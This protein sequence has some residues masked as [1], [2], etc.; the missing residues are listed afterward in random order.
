MPKNKSEEDDQNRN[1]PKW[2]IKFI[3]HPESLLRFSWEIFIATFLLFLGFLIPY[4]SAFDNNNINVN[5]VINIQS[6][7]IF[8]IDIILTM[9]TAYYDKG[10]IIKDRLKIFRNYLSFWFWIDA[11]TTFPFDWLK[12]DSDNGNGAKLFSFFK[13]VRVAKLLKLIRLAKLKI[14]I[15]RIEDQIAN[16]TLINLMIVLKLLVYLFLIAHFFAC[17]MFLISSS[18]MSPDGFANL[19]VNKCDKPVLSPDELYVS[20]L[21]WAFVTMASI[22]Y[23]DFYPKSTNEKMFGVFTML[24]SSVV[25]GVIIGNIGTLMEKNSLKA[26]AR[27]DALR[28]INLFFLKYNIAP[29][30]KY[31]A[32][33]YIDYAF[34]YD[35]YNENY[36][37]DILSLLS[38]P[39]QEEIL[40]CTNGTVLHHCKIFRIFSDSGINRLAKLLSIKIFSPLDSIIKEGQ[41]SEGMYFIIKGGAEVFDYATSCKI[42]TLSSRQYFGEIGLFTRQPCVSSVVAHNFSENLFLSVGNFDTI[43]NVIPSAKLNIDEIKRSCS[44][45]NYFALN[46]RCYSCH[47]HGHIAKNCQVILNDEILR[48][49]WIN[50][51]NRSKLVNLNEQIR[52][53]YRRKLR[54]V[55]K[56]DYSAK[57][58][59]GKKRKVGKMYPKLV[60][61]VA[62]I[63]N[64]F[65]ENIR[66]YDGNGVLHTEE[67]IISNSLHQNAMRAQLILTSSEEEDNENEGKSIIREKKFCPFNAGYSKLF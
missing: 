4:L 57:N 65:Q 23:G 61:L 30:L 10:Y 37:G 1:L 51:Q 44:E 50:R 15:F 45:G 36:I 24:F 28:N 25:F 16:Q 22:G 31:K 14:L 39:L 67:S 8:S 46:I 40:L 43:A 9:N 12:L 32:R 66:E 38:Q 13:L 41:A 54:I 56:Y 6:F 62:N 63:R 47:E 52:M 55:K 53:K 18:D 27:R 26:K 2:R 29:N 3:M 17:M 21:Y 34:H 42:I 49:N 35:K 19:I 33:R 20:S 59:L 64:F 58:V 11:L 60:R 7:V 5:N 48:V